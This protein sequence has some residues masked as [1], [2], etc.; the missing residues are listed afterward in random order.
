MGLSPESLYPL[1]CTLTT[2]FRV[3]NKKRGL[4]RSWGEGWE[5]EIWKERKFCT[6]CSSKVLI[7]RARCVTIPSRPQAQSL[8]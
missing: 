1:I 7:G 2:T 3:P 8:T 5:K 6:V 4:T